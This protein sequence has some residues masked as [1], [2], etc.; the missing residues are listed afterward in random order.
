MR[1]LSNLEHT[2]LGLTWLRQP[3]TT[4]AV[5]KELESSASSY[6]KSRAGAVYA[7]M[8]RLQGF[9]LIELAE[10]GSLSVTRAGEQELRDWMRPPIPQGD[11][12]Y[13]V[14]LIRLRMFFLGVLEPPEREAF[15][16]SAIA[17][18]EQFLSECTALI[19]ENEAIGDYFGVLAT[20][21]TIIETRARIEWLHIARRYLEVP[22]PDGQWAKTAFEVLGVDAQ[23]Q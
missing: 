14:D 1:K 6:H 2:V 4:Y 20:M 22:M 7:A 10:S 11:V 18:L 21:S 19:P 15:I 8:R 9:G 16:D 17:G 12:T 13:T 3:C 23:P 5:M